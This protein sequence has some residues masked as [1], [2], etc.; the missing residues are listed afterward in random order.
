MVR[1]ASSKFRVD[2][3]QDAGHQR[4]G[5][6]DE[7]IARRRNAL[8][9]RPDHAEGYNQ[10]CIALA[11]QNRFDEAADAFGSALSLKPDLALAHDNLGA[12]LSVQGKVCE[13]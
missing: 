4:R 10:S 5:R 11:A 1:Y 12:L 6:S 9:L 8:R 3:R 13:A 2:P 7:A